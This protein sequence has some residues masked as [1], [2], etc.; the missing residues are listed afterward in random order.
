MSLRTCAVSLPLLSNRQNSF[1]QFFG[2]FLHHLRIGSLPVY[3]G[4]P[5][6]VETFNHLCVTV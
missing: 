2:R 6:G 1:N 5:F 3:F 4:R